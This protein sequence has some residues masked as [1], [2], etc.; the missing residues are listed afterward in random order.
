M[1]AGVLIAIVG[2]PAA[3][4]PWGYNP[5]GPPK[6]M[7]LM[8]AAAVIAV[9]LALDRNAARRARA[10]LGGSKFAWVALATAGLASL[11]VATSLDPVRSLVGS[12]AE[13][14]GIASLAACLMVGIGVVCVLAQP[15]GPRALGR[16]VAGLLIFSG[17]YAVAQRAGL[18]LVAV[19][20]SYDVARVRATLGNA[21]NMGVFLCLAAPWAVGTLLRD[22]SRFWRVMAG[23]ALCLSA[24]ALVWT[25]SRGAWVGAAA[26]ALVGVA[27]ASRGSGVRVAGRRLGIA[28][29]AI[30]VLAA[31]ALLVPGT[32]ARIAGSQDAGGTAAWRLVAWR[33]AASMA[34]DRPLLGWGPGAF[35]YAYPRYRLPEAQ[36]AQASGQVITDAH[37]VVLQTAASS[38]LAT[39]F[40][41]VLVFALAMRTAWGTPRG[42]PDQ[43]RRMPDAALVAASLAAGA[44]ALMF[45]FVTLDSAVL[46]ALGIGSTVA[47]DVAGADGRSRVSETPSRVEQAVRYGAVLVGMI[48]LAGALAAATLCVAD[49]HVI[50]GF[51]LARRGSWTTAASEF[52]AAVAL[53]PWE[54]AVVWAKGRAAIDV[55]GKSADPQALADGV[56]ALDAAHSALPADAAVVLDR[57]NLRL[58]AGITGGDRALLSASLPDL[59]VVLRNDPYN[60][61]ALASRATAKAGLGDLAESVADYERSIGLS[62]PSRT[63]LLNLAAVYE[64]LGRIGDAADARRRADTID[65]GGTPNGQ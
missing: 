12:Y 49:T 55:A 43:A 2:V 59:D 41:L 53:A 17:L 28:V 37:N 42:K 35:R 16:A 40:G 32:A 20:M 29:G 26:G 11:S 63:T 33:S 18:D 14:Q 30:A 47:M 23:A 34:W 61:P 50:R 38:G 64:K 57:A 31:L 65:I 27:F 36:D 7:V 10:A 52:D 39:A 22:P 58:A 8:V 3:M 9:G 24:I 60:A 5:Y 45:H 6:L 1:L 51:A 44:A 25:G 19:R 56:A 48:A 46:V 21:S 54:P 15:T 62:S 13:Y 4:D